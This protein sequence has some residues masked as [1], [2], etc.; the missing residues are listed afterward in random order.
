MPKNKV[1]TVPVNKWVFQVILKEKHSSI[2]K[3]G[4]A[5]D[6]DFT[7]KTI[8]RAL[9]NGEMRPELVKQIAIHL[10]IDSSL[11][12]GEMVKEAFS[13]KNKVF[14]DLYL[15]PLA[16]LDDFPY[17]RT[18]SRELSEIKKDG[19]FETG[20]MPETMKRLL[21]LFDVAYKQYEELDFETQYNF[22]HDLFDAMIPI[23]RKYFKKNAYGNDDVLAFESIIIE[24]ENYKENH[25]LLEYADK[26]LRKKYIDNPPKGLS[27]AD[28]QSMSSQAI[29][30]YDEALQFEAY[31]DDPNYK[32]PLL[33]K[34]E[35][36]P[37]IE[38]NDTDEDV[39]RKTQEAKEKAL[40]RRRNQN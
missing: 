13:A 7:E 17:F 4:A 29:L 37:L 24:L 36:Y 12:T 6:I 33:L 28:I 3:L 30:D 26:T 5:E 38:E 21:S 22:E 35:D 18:E 11:L 34:Y 1:K 32:S 14:R 39:R 31:T 8:R 19:L 27:K 40:K 25:D 23:I 15:D 9:N 2:R 20:G 16:H 10:N